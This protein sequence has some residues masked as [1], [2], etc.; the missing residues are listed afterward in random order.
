M[1]SAW[2]AG[3]NKYHSFRAL[4]AHTLQLPEVAMIAFTLMHTITHVCVR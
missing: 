3:V 4:A 1:E 2:F